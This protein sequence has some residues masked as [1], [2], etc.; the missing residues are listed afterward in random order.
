MITSHQR[1]R[2]SFTRKLHLAF[3]ALLLVTLG[4]AWYF[5]DS[6]KWYEHDVQ[7][8]A[9]AN[10]V[11]FSYQSIAS[12]TNGMLHGLSESI[13]SGVVD[14]SR[15]GPA[16]SQQLR[17]DLN[18]VRD[19]I[20]QELVQ[21]GQLNTVLDLQ[22]EFDIEHVVQDILLAN[23]R[24]TRAL[25]SG[26]VD[27]AS[28]EFDRLQTSGSATLFRQ[29]MDGVLQQRREQV[30]KS[31]RQAVELA[32]YITGVLPLFVVV[33]TLVTLIMVAVFSRSLT[34]SINELQRGAEAFGK[35]DFSYRIPGL[36]EKNFARLG[37]AFNAMAADLAEHRERLH[38]VNVGLESVV[39][40]R[41]RALQKSNEKLATIDDNRRRLLADISHEF[42]TPLTV[43]QGEAEIALRSKSKAIADY[44]ET[45]QRIIE[46]AGQTTHL[47]DDLLFIARAEGGEPRL[48]LQQ[49]EVSEQLRT[50]CRN[51]AAQAL[52]KNITVIEQFPDELPL[53]QADAGRMRQVFSILLDNALRYGNEQGEVKVDASHMAEEL[54]VTIS[55]NGPGISAAEADL[56]F[57]RFYR[58][59]P[60]HDQPQGTGLGLPV[61]KAI[62]E[63]HHGRIMLESGVDGGAVASVILPLETSPEEIDT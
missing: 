50:V 52:L 8:I 37:E 5:Y 47:I 26:D 7:K 28:A 33:L 29:L 15:N 62:V 27:G 2:T 38:D 19:T 13:S 1:L 59:N 22:P 63:A 6:V 45:L 42:R 35:G 9:T 55:D 40:E 32:M 31:H 53:L 12:L 21:A 56:V 46:Q 49:I 43:I 44:R 24:I 25:Q 54:V 16:I 14:E 58:S 20:V 41:T 4:L 10:Q 39:E 18:K 51:F 23:D 61:A 57:Q 36:G 60:Q 17:Q 3:A 34:R 30:Q 48:H 11:L